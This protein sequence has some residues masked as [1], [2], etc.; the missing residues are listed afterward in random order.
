MS[1]LTITALSDP[2]FTEEIEKYPGVA[3]VDFWAGWCG[4]CR[5]VAPI[6]EELAAAYVGTI[7]VAKLDVDANSDTPQ[8][9]GI[10]SIPTL[11][12][13]RNGRVIDT[14]VGVLPKAL[15]DGRFRAAADSLTSVH[16]PTEE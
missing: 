16:A 4:P 9:Y 2:T 7:K 13:F 15:L 14:V 11:L 5:A 10:R 1:S 12:F 3:V 6:V 8:R